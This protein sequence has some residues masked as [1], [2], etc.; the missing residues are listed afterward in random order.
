M[1]SLQDIPCDLSH[2]WRYP[3]RRA[4][5]TPPRQFGG[6]LQHGRVDECRDDLEDSRRPLAN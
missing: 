5:G 4:A 3:S 1:P 6:V 2:C